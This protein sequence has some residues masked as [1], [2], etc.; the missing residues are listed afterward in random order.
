MDL[1]SCGICFGNWVVLYHHL[2]ITCKNRKTAYGFLENRNW[3]PCFFL[4]I[5]TCWLLEIPDENWVTILTTT[6]PIISA[7]FTGWGCA[8]STPPSLRWDF[9]ACSLWDMCK[10]VSL[11]HFRWCESTSRRSDSRNL[12]LWTPWQASHGRKASWSHHRH[13]ACERACLIAAALHQ[14]TSLGVEFVFHTSL[15]QKI[16]SL[17]TLSTFSLHSLIQ[18]VSS[19]ET[20]QCC[21]S[22]T[23]VA[24][25]HFTMWIESLY[26]STGVES[27]LALWIGSVIV[28]LVVFSQRTETAAGQQS[29]SKSPW[30]HDACLK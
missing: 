18:K 21:S 16:E 13:R 30:K 10:K 15:V 9:G 27:H 26:R 17:C 1:E 23:S 29:S 6:P 22:F 19:L 7:L 11:S 28:F 4:S 5:R 14:L 3:K 2:T 8:G 20:W 12:W 24:I 25:F